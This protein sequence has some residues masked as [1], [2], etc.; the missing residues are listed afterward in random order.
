MI[1][2]MR[3]HPSARSETNVRL[4]SFSSC[5]GLARLA[6]TVV[7][8][9]RKPSVNSSLRPSNNARKPTENPR[10]ANRL[11]VNSE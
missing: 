5:A 11:F 7:T 10:P 3:T 8:G 2:A 9:T 4:H 1:S 6:A